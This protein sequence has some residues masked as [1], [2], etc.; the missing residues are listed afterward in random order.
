MRNTIVRNTVDFCFL[1]L[2]EISLNF[3]ISVNGLSGESLDSL[4]SVHVE[5]S[6]FYSIPYISFLFCV[7]LH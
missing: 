1:I 4:S 3:L 5:F 6:F 2:I 7:F